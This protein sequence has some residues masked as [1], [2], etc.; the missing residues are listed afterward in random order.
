[1]AQDPGRPNSPPAAN[2]LS[3][4]TERELAVLAL[5]A[6]GK[7]NKEIAFALYITIHTV[8]AHTSKIFY[9]LGNVRRVEA[10]IIYAMHSSE[11]A[12]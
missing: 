10:A 1:M 3:R 6:E 8:K 2:P 11:D 9:K 5:I 7:S 4:L 12:A